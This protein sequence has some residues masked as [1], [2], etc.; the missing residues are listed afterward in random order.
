MCYHVSVNRHLKQLELEMKRHLVPEQR[1]LY[2]PYYHVSG[3]AKPFVPVISNA[4]TSVLQMYRWGLIPFW[5]KDEAAFRANTL[6]AKSETLFES[7]SYKNS[8]R[9]RC[10]VTVSAFFEPHLNK[11]AGRKENHIVKRKDDRIITLGAIWSKWNGLPTFSIITTAASPLM[12]EVHNEK[13]RMPLVLDGDRA[14][15]WLLPDITKDEMQEL[16]TTP[17]VD[18]LLESY[19]V[20]DGVTNARIDS[21]VPEVLERI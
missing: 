5:V 9:N 12:A 15:A 6:N 18:H 17:D 20:M 19:R 14:G 1:E 11:A 3:F 2:Q 8:W 10:L 4:D 21:N 16:M 7:G 13:M